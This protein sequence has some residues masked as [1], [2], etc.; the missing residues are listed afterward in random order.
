MAESLAVFCVFCFLIAFVTSVLLTIASKRIALKF[1]L[2]AHPRSDRFHKKAVPLGGGIAIFFTMLLAFLVAIA[3]IKALIADNSTELFDRDFGA[4]ITGFENRMEELWMIMGCSAVLFLL[5]LLDDMSNLKPVPKLLVEFIVAFIAAY[6]ADV[7]LEFFIE[8]RLLTSIISSFWIVL[9]INA[10]NFLDNMDGASAGIAAIISLIM[11]VVAVL[12]GQVFVAGL[13]MVFAG[14]LIG[15]LVFNFHPAS[16]FMGDAGSLVTGFFIAVLSLRTTYFS[17]TQD[18]RWYTILMPLVILA[19][20][21]YDFISV[22]ALR[23]HQGKSPFIGDT[24]HFSHRLKKRGLN[25]IQAVLM[26]YLATITTGLGAIVLKVA[27]WPYGVLVFMQAIMVLAI[28][29][30]LESTGNNEKN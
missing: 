25:E 28:I 30:I 19:I 18:I 2:L 13:A 10:F 3:L 5:G 4:Y 7:R 16:I 27:E 11:Y 26:L 29:A 6:M 24:Q 14:A 8:S 1:G 17:S 22:T 21:L 20:P 9:I 23:L 15:F 12:A